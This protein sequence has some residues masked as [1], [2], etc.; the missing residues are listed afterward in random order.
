MW[1]VPLVPETPRG[2]S[3]YQNERLGKKS[4]WGGLVERKLVGRSA[5]A[6]ERLIGASYYATCAWFEDIRM[7]EPANCLT[8]AE[9]DFH[10]GGKTA[11]CFAPL[12]RP[13]DPYRTP[14]SGLMTWRNL[15]NI[16][17]YLWAQGQSSPPARRWPQPRRPRRVTR[18]QYASQLLRNQ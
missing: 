8:R 3:V 5:E 17:T 1:N 6:Y 15:I 13:Q 2:I 11:E 18:A 12:P 9:Q 10:L 14:F 4:W 16:Y 7:A